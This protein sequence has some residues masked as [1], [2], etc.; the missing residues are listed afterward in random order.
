M[1]QVTFEPS[2]LNP[3]SKATHVFS[4][5]SR[6]LEIKPGRNSYSQEELDWLEAQAGFSRLTEA[7][8]FVIVS[9]MVETV[10]GATPSDLTSYLKMKTDEAIALIGTIEDV[11]LLKAWDEADKRVTVS[12]EISK[13]IAALTA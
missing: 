3:P 1:I 12:T 7:N 8:A 4:D 2:R 9:T 5:D 13:R 6:S 10:G 11:V